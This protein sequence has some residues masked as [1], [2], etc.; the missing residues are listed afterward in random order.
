MHKHKICFWLRRQRLYKNLKT[1]KIQH[2]QMKMNI[3]I[4]RTTKPNN[5]EA[6]KKIIHMVNSLQ[7]ETMERTTHLNQMER[8]TIQN[9][10]V[11]EIIMAKIINQVKVMQLIHHIY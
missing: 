1:L 8:R 4:L 9:H 5:M 2:I 10:K 11:M 6:A 3:Q 7:R